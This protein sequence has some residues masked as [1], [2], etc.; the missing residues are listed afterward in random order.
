MYFIYFL[1]IVGL[2]TTKNFTVIVR[3][4]NDPPTGISV[5]RP[6]NVSE[7]SVSGQYLGTV[8]TADQDV[9]QTHQYQIV[10]VVGHAHGNH[11]YDL[12]VD[13]DVC[14]CRIVLNNHPAL[15]VILC[16]LSSELRTLLK[17]S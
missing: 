2:S 14:S 15:F 8:V 10:D 13:I 11:R 17:K 9:G 1:F 16:S 4:R 3:D 7:N 6:L 12:I 5:S